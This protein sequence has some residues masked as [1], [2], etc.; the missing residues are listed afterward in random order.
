MLHA[1]RAAVSC[2]VAALPVP[3]R[4]TPE[5]PTFQA[6]EDPCWADLP[7]GRPFPTALD[8]FTGNRY[9][10]AA[11][12]RQ[13][14]QLAAGGGA[15]IYWPQTMAE[16]VDRP[17]PNGP[18]RVQ[19]NGHHSGTVEVDEIIANVGF[20]PSNRIYEELQIHALLVLK[21]TT[22]YA[23]LKTMVKSLLDC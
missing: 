13:A 5:R 17:Q 11:L 16:R 9:E 4:T 7:G 19:L 3:F 15:I 14:N 18:F 2:H 23:H 22:A 1:V 21:E 10:R 6:L 12:A 20:R 8:A